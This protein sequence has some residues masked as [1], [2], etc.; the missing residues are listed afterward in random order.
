[1]VELE[2]D[3]FLRGE[4]IEPEANVRI[5]TEGEASEIPVKEGEKKIP[6]F[7]I[8]VILSNG[9]MKTWTVNKTSQRT[10]SSVWGTDTAKWVD[11]VATLYVV[12]QPVNKVMKKVIYARV[13]KQ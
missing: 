7:E 4:D 5:A 13:P 3:A 9:K 8:N 2:I 10:L 1:M 6:T 11:K 12:E